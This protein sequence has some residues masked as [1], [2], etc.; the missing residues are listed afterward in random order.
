MMKTG[1]SVAAG[2]EDEMGHDDAEKV[3]LAGW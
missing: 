1:L 3:E 2:G